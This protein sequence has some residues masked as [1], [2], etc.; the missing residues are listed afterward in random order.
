MAS[1]WFREPRRSPARASRRWQPRRRFATPSSTRPTSAEPPADRSFKEIT[2]AISFCMASL[3]A[4]AVCAACF[5]S[6]TKCSLPGARASSP[7]FS[8]STK[9]QQATGWNVASTAVLTQPSTSVAPGTAART[10]R[11][12]WARS[13]SRLSTASTSS[14]RRGVFAFSRSISKA[15]CPGG[16]LNSQSA[17]ASVAGGRLRTPAGSVLLAVTDWQLVLS[18]K[19]VAI[20]MSPRFATRRPW[21]LRDQTCSVTFVTTCVDSSFEDL[22]PRKPEDFVCL[23]TVTVGPSTSRFRSPT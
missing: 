16:K 3:A 13:W 21:K 2:A 11:A 19:S 15:T 5:M 20:S 23:S 4:F 12:N 22:P 6:A 14:L 1:M 17:S 10:D 18:V 8:A 9:A 7:P